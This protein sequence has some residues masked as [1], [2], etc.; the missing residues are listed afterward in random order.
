MTRYPTQSHYH[1]RVLPHGFESYDLPKRETGAHL[2]GASFGGPCKN[3]DF[4]Q[5]TLG[6]CAICENIEHGGMLFT[7]VV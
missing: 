6:C 1:Q 3:G 4:P 7:T 2:I 5:I